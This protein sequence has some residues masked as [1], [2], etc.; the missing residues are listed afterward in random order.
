M[1]KM[2]L[3]ALAVMLLSGLATAQTTKIIVGPMEGFD[4]APID[5]DTSQVLVI[6]VYIRTAPGINI[7]A[8]HLP[9][10]SN[11]DYIRPDSREAGDFFYPL[12]LWDDVS[13][14]TPNE[15]PVNSGY[16]NHSILGI[17]DMGSE[18]P[19]SVNA[20]RTNGQF[21]QVATFRMTTQPFGDGLVHDDAFM[22]GVQN[23]NGGLVFADFVTGEMDND[24]IEV[25][26]STLHLPDTQTG[27]DDEVVEIPTSYGLNQ[28]YPNPFNA[29]TTISY[30][31]P[32]GSD[33]TIDIYDIM[34]R[35]VTTLVSGYQNAGTHSAIWNA[36][37]VSSG[38]Y[39]YKLTAG[40]YTETR[41]C[42]LL[43]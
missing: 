25:S 18:D 9:V 33:V 19:D 5:A 11:D 39:L 22:L 12:P 36:N 31:L 29:H 20:I 41:R 2:L 1:K 3:L 23:D 42:N 24:A 34:G 43:K 38:V 26:Y 14:L 10:A 8:L 30:S 4:A 17:K 6:P 16:M 40:N 27:I 7:V 28:N 13:Y 15:D 32:E 35:K 37:D 21:L